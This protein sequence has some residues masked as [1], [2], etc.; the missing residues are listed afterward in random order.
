MAGLFAETL[1]LTPFA[2][3]YLVWR[4]ATGIGHFIDGDAHHRFLL[5]LAGPVTAIPLL[6]FAAAANR[7]NL[8]VLGLMQYFN[9]TMQVILALFLFGEQMLPGQAIT[10][11]LIWLGLVLY[12]VL[13]RLGRRPLLA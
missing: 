2:I 9:P 11:T 8:Q 4:E 7:L 12:S 1:I 3:G 6:F 5:L 10:F 13:P